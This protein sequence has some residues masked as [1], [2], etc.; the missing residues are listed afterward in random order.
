MKKWLLTISLFSII[1]FAQS[2]VFSLSFKIGAK[3]GFG[4]HAVNVA[5]PGYE[6]N[7]TNAIVGGTYGG[8]IDIIFMDFGG[9]SF[10]VEFDFLFQRRGGEYADGQEKI[11][12]FGFPIIGKVYFMDIL[13]GG[14]GVAYQKK[15]KSSHPGGSNVKEE[16]IEVLISVGVNFELINRVFFTA[17][18]RASAGLLNYSTNPFDTLYTRSTELL[19]GVMFKAF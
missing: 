11:D 6:D 4:I 2:D 8:A 1:F 14:V 9:L 18:I 7:L 15:L 16:N 5:Q 19:F 3:G 17:E 13:Y 12:Y 10:G